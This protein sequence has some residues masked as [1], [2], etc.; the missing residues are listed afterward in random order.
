VKNGRAQSDQVRGQGSSIAKECG[1]EE[2]RDYID[3]SC[4]AIDQMRGQQLVEDAPE[5]SGTSAQRN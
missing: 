4:R 3:Q 2:L 1:L 5:Q